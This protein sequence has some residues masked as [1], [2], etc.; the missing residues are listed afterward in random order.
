MNALARAATAVRRW[1]RSADRDDTVVRW[2]AR[3]P[4]H[5]ALE[6]ALALRHSALTTGR[7]LR[8]LERQGRVT[9]AHVSD[10]AFTYRLYT[11]PKET[12]R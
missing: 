3:H 12:A 11:A 8:R 2:L 10:E 4:H 7:R 6:V 1:W 5:E 9:S